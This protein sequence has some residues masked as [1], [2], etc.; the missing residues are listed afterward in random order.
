M[1][2]T[3]Q[4]V[5]FRVQLAPRIWI[6]DT[7]LTPGLLARRVIKNELEVNL[8]IHYEFRNV[9]SEVRVHVDIVVCEVGDQLSIN[10]S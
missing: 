2:V 6:A 9:Y 1:T 4:S 3:R 8:T 7:E 10:R 5:S